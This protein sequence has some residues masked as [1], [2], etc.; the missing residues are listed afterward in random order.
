MV[1][2]FGKAAGKF[3]N[4]VIHYPINIFLFY[5][6]VWLLEKATAFPNQ[7]FWKVILFVA[8]EIFVYVLFVL[9][10]DNMLNAFT[11]IMPGPLPEFIEVV[12]L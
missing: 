12:T 11:N 6:N 7:S 3:A 5:I 10:L 9:G 2:S 4:F 1:L 8:I